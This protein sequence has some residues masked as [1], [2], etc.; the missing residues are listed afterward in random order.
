MQVAFL[1]ISLTLAI[2]SPQD[3]PTFQETGE[4]TRAQIAATARDWRNVAASTGNAWKDN[5]VTTGDAAL[6]ATIQGSRADGDT[7][8]GAT[9]ASGQAIDDVAESGKKKFRTKF[10]EWNDHVQGTS[11]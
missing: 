11:N 10:D 5:I 9:V 8:V 4:Q 3:Q 7:I 1:L 6:G 2:A